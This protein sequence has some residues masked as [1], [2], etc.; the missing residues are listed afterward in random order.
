M[1]DYK[2][3]ELGFVSLWSIIALLP[4]CTIGYVAAGIG[5]MKLG[6]GMVFMFAMTAYIMIYAYNRAE[7]LKR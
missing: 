6:F 7:E 3:N 5:G 2:K 1:P 4:F